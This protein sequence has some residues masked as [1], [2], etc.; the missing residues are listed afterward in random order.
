V[1]DR[2]E[3]AGVPIRQLSQ[4]HRVDDAEDRG[5]RADAERERENDDE[6]ER[7]RM[8]ETPRGIP[9]VEV[10][11]DIDANGI[12][13][14]QAKDNATGREQKITITASSGLSKDDIDKIV[15]EAEKH[16][17]EDKK[18]RDEVDTRN[19]AESITYQAEKTLKEV[20][21][22]VPE[23]DKKELQEQSD[24]LKEMLKNSANT[25]DLKKQ[26]EKLT[27]KWHKVSTAMYE[28]TKK[29]QGAPGA[30]PNAGPN[31]AGEKKSGDD[32]V[33]AEYE[34]V[35]DEKKKKDKK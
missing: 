15:K 20:G 9:Q 17:D 18:K 14:V 19:Q 32:V 33:D 22:K 34:V 5:V 28:A 27:E 21:D 7:G 35:D 3:L 16:S 8:P 10:T 29:D 1:V 12:L 30:G 4:Q 13:H 6:R 26:M 23:A 11:F 25:E 31:P 2:D 24:K